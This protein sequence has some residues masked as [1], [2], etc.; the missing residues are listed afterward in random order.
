MHPSTSLLIALVMLICSSACW[1]SSEV[2]C[3][4]NKPPFGMF[5]VLQDL[6]AAE[7]WRAALSRAS[8][9]K[10]LDD[11]KLLRKSLKREEQDKARK[12]K[13]WQER[14]TAQQEQQQKKQDK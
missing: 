10:V 1:Q 14:M 2:L 12:Q 4:N 3:G 6:V 13:R 9:E 11:P 5:A 7:A 8:G